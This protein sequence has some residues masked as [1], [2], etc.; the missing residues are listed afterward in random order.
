MMGDKSD[1]L[2]YFYYFL[3]LTVKFY[4]FI[5][6]IINDINRYAYLDTHVPQRGKI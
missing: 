6:F 4:L 3:K 5:T 2:L 1:K